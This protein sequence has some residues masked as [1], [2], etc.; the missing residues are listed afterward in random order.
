MKIIRFL[1]P[2]ILIGICINSNAAEIKV[3]GSPGQLD[4]RVAGENAIDRKSTRL[5]SSH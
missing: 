3:N 1:L 4:I 5:N 2:V